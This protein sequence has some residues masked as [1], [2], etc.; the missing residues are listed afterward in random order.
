LTTRQAR[1]PPVLWSARPSVTEK[2]RNHVNQRLY[3]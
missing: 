1:V 3:R 2:E